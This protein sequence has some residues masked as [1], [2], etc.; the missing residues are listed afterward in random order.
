MEK[1]P[2][3]IVGVV[4]GKKESPY[5]LL[6]YSVVPRGIPLT[7]EDFARTLIELQKKGG[8]GE[9]FYVGKTQEEDFLVLGTPAFDVFVPFEPEL[10]GGIVQ[11]ISVNY[12]I[13]PVLVEFEESSLTVA[14]G[15]P[16]ELG[17]V[18][19]IALAEMV[20]E[21]ILKEVQEFSP[22]DERRESVD[23]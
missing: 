16:K 21:G 11:V 3:V 6:A 12:G 15:L 20:G 10:F 5:P 8:K 4:E 18:L 14:F 9:G 17:K 23:G 7:P 13:L 2:L 19:R 22:S 1:L